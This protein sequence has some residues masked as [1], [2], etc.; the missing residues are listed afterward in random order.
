[1]DLELSVGVRPGVPQGLIIPLVGWILPLPRRFGLVGTNERP[2]VVHT[3][4]VPSSL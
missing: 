1:V 3:A 4:P 2:Q